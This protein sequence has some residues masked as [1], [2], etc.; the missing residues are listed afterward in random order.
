MALRSVAFVLACA[1]ALV[2]Q[3]QVAPLDRAAVE[4]ALAALLAEPALGGA[5]IGVV[6]AQG[7]EAAFVVAHDADKGFL[8]A[9]NM[10]LVSGAVALATLG[11]D[12]R[13]TTRVQTAAALADGVLQGDLLLVGDGDPSLGGRPATDPFEPMRDLVRQLG[14]AGVKR[15]G[16]RIVG[17]DDCQA[18]EHIGR[19]WQWD[20]LGDD[21][22][23]QFGGLCFAENAATLFVSG[24]EEGSPPLLR[25]EPDI[26]YV[27]GRADFT[28][29]PADAKAAL[30]VTRQPFTN[31]FLVR[32]ALPAGAAEQRFRLSV[33]NPT[34]YAAQGLAGALQRAGVQTG[35]AVDGDDVGVPAQ[36]WR[37][38][39]Q[40]QSKPL[41]ELMAPMMKDSQNLY[42]EQ[43]ARTAARVA[44]S[45][46][47]RAATDAHVREAL[48]KLGIDARGMVLADQS[49]LSR[50][51]L[52]QPRQLVALLQA[53]WAAPFRDVYF[54]S[55]PVAGVDGTLRGRLRETAAK[56]R[57]RAKTGT[58]DMVSALSGV[59]DPQDPKHPPVFFSV[60]LNHY[61]CTSA[62]ARDAMD[63]FLDALARAAGWQ[64]EPPAAAPK[65]SGG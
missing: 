10:K 21:Y 20:Y 3:D 48:A 38:L 7:S 31:S 42:A 39:A 22:A 4:K 62:Q 6:V 16:G 57:L 32:G 60:M 30:D 12:F 23:A 13:W 53:M 58:I 17:V 14:E 1:S 55:L 5:R 19:G 63:R 51:N 28:C 64:A 34:R 25:V 2:A 24:T 52:V 15:I 11:A 49:G 29:G 45:N 46:G 27:L 36:P 9:S 40:W 26:R 65:G 56:G 44:G 47:S 54:E 35:A 61:T 50:R 33:E 37:E 8:P 18:D 43:F 59:L 41:R